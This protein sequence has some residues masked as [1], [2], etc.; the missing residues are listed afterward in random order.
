ML[1]KLQLKRKYAIQPAPLGFEHY[2]PYK[3]F[4]MYHDLISSDLF[5]WPK[6]I[7]WELYLTRLQNEEIL[8]FATVTDMTVHCCVL[9]L[10]SPFSDTGALA[11]KYALA[12][13]LV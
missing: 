11:L 3:R 9:I 12:Q 4:Q 1:T 2:L 6:D 10:S 5:I 8:I 13:G 7:F